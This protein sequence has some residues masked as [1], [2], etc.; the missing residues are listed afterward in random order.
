LLASRRRGRCGRSP[1]GVQ[2]NAS[3]KPF[4]VEV[5]GGVVVDENR[6]PLILNA[7]LARHPEADRLRQELTEHPGLESPTRPALSGTRGHRGME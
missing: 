4:Y 1:R 7:L 3:Y 6:L 2:T 5:G